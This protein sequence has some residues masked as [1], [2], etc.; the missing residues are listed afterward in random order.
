M[1]LLEFHSLG[2]LRD[3]ASPESS[4]GGDEIFIGKSSFVKSFEAM[5]RGVAWAVDSRYLRD[6]SGVE[7]GAK[8]IFLVLCGR[9]G[10]NVFV[11][12]GLSTMDEALKMLRAVAIELLLRLLEGTSSRV[13]SCLRADVPRGVPRPT[14]PYGDA[15]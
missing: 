12:G 3:R 4:G 10:E 1:E 14:E 7:P 8:S 5:P 13:R 11:V 2:T 15:A 9:L 6:G